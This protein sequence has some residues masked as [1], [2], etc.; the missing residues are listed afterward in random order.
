M[1]LS[2][3]PI[4]S[5]ASAARLSASG[6]SNRTAAGSSAAACST[7]SGSVTTAARRAS[8][9]PR[10]SA[11]RPPPPARDTTAPRASRSQAQLDALRIQPAGHVIDQRRIT[12]PRPTDRR[13]RRRVAT[14]FLDQREHARAACVGRVEILDEPPAPVRGV[15]PGGIFGDGLFQERRRRLVRLHLLGAVEQLFEL[16]APILA[17]RLDPPALG[18]PVLPLDR[19]DATA[20]GAEQ[21]E[22][23]LRLAVDEF[24]P[25]LD[26]PV[27]RARL[28]PTRP[29]TRSRARA[30]ARAARR[31][32][33]PCWPRARPRPRR[34]RSR[35]GTIHP[36]CPPF[37]PPRVAP[38][39]H[40]PRDPPPCN[41]ATPCGA[42]RVAGRRCP[43]P[44]QPGHLRLVG[45][46]H[47]HAVPLRLRDDEHPP[48]I[49]GGVNERHV[50]HAPSGG[51]PA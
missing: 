44:G 20:G 19:F 3:E 28:R 27:R 13:L 2:A 37:N 33:D 41:P 23:D 10:Q 31:R 34:S 22:R 39:T 4:A 5:P 45:A 11:R 17:Q 30:G 50:R 16:L 9:R 18:D 48:V 25:E 15:L 46:V 6:G 36:A 24:R 51:R 14:P 26:R 42:L 1:T 35:H 12:P 40:N 32:R 8:S 29:P 43:V 21:V 49:H 47:L 38:S 7:P